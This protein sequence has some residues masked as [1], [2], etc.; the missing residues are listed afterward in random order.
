[1]TPSHYRVLESASVFASHKHVHK[2]HEEISDENKQS[3]VKPTLRT[4]NRKIFEAFN[5]GDYLTV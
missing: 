5:V 4:D 2:L 1:V 3:N